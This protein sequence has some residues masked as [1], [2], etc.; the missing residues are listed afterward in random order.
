MEFHMINMTYGALHMRA[1]TEKTT[2][3]CKYDCTLTKHTRRY[4]FLL[5]HN[6]Q[7]WVYRLVL[8][9]PNVRLWKN[10]ILKWRRMIAPPP[11]LIRVNGGQICP[12]TPPPQNEN[13]WEARLLSKHSTDKIDFPK[14]FSYF[15][16]QWFCTSGDLRRTSRYTSGHPDKHHFTVTSSASYREREKS[17]QSA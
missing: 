16:Q 9:P 3:S 5:D 17:I 12:P 13:L 14:K 15:P 11:V 6:G 2:F 7:T 8:S 10:V 4:F 1:Q